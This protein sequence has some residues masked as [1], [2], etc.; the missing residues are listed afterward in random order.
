MTFLDDC[1]TAGTDPVADPETSQVSVV[2][3]WLSSRPAD[4]F[5]QLRERAPTV[6]LGRLALLTRYA[7]VVDVCTARDGA[8]SVKPYGDAMDR[9][10]EGVPYLLGM[11]E[12]PE[13]RQRLGWLQAAFTRDDPARARRL[14]A[15]HAGN[16]I[17]AALPLGRLDV[18]D[19]YGRLVP[20]RFVADDFG[21]HGIDPSL[22][23]K[24]ARDLF[25]DAFVNA[26]AIPV[27]SRRAV[28]AARAF[29]SHIER[30]VALARADIAAGR[31]RT[32]TVIGRLAALQAAGEP[33]LTDVRIRD[34]VLWCAAGM[35]DNISTGVCSVLDVLFE[36]PPAMA[37][38]MD[39]A[40]AA[41]DARLRACVLEALRFRTP[42][43]VIFRLARRSYTFSPGTP[44]EATVEPGTLVLAGT[45]AAM[46][47]PDVF[48]DPRRFRLDRP[49]GHDLHFGAGMHRCLGQSLG[50]THMVEMVAALLRL[51]GLRR[52]RGASGHLHMA[53]VFPAGFDVEFDVVGRA[54]E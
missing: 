47:D 19:R 6:L 35:I 25:T 1:R 28:E 52:A 50:M 29:R 30:D 22:L 21:L 11:D 33:G 8:F 42:L 20:S 51:P 53:G 13:Y 32:D 48:E 7:D 27:L 9:V 5:E 15:E 14:V 3:E 49:P 4:L 18:P 36:H 12:S 2:R 45:G 40:R 16:A 43:P 37:A 54:G 38:A 10:N 24:W 26:F 17:R 44:H 46:M 39:A 34:D 41:D 23:M 31:A